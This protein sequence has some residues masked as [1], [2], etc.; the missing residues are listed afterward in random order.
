MY[1]CY[2]FWFLCIYTMHKKAYAFAE[3]I[4]KKDASASQTEGI[5]F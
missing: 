5:I 2:I 1:V 4:D 3:N